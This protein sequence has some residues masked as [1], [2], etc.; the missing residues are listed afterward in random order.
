MFVAI[1]PG[2]RRNPAARAGLYGRGLGELPGGKPAA[3]AND[4]VKEACVLGEG[5][6]YLEE[7]PRG[8]RSLL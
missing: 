1:R 6:F 4:E 5:D 3:D 2:P 8:K 7:D